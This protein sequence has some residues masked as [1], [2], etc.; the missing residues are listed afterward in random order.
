[1]IIQNNP[2]LKHTP[3]SSLLCDETIYDTRIKQINKI[4]DYF[5]NK[6]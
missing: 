3:S 6:Q 5:N 2:L 4:I 1:M